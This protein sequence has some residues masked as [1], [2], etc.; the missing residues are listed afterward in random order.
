MHR[1]L[2][3]LA[4]CLLCLPA[5]SCRTAP[6]HTPEPILIQ[7]PR[8]DVR[9]AILRAMVHR[10]WRPIADDPGKITAKVLVRGKH[11]AVVDIVYTQD[12][13]EFAYVSSDNLEY[14]VA[15]DQAIIH[16]NY[17][18]WV[19]L[20]RDDIAAELLASKPAGT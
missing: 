17:N 8:T 12:K 5:P 16:K 15:D 7:Q 1:A 10:G 18:S 19:E 20:L 6:L 14:E 3:T 2:P 9:E 13:V 4:L 11:E